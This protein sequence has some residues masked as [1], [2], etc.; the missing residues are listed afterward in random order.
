MHRVLPITLLAAV[1]LGLPGMALAGGAGP[2]DLSVRV[3]PV[4][5]DDARCALVRG[6]DPSAAVACRTIARVS[7]LE[8]AAPNGP[9][10]L[11]LLEPGRHDVPVPVQFRGM[12]AVAGPGAVQAVVNLI[13]AGSLIFSGGVQ[14]AYVGV[15]GTAPGTWISSAGQFNWFF[16]VTIARARAN[17]P[18]VSMR[19]NNMHLFNSLVSAPGNEN[20]VVMRGSGSVVGSTISGG[21]L[22][23]SADG[24]GQD[25][26]A[27]VVNASVLQGGFTSLGGRPAV[28]NS[29]ITTPPQSNSSA[30]KV[31]D[32]SGL[33]ADAPVN[34]PYIALSSIWQRACSP[35]VT[36]FRQGP[37]GREVS[38][39][40]AGSLVRMPDP[41]CGNPLS[42][43][44]VV[45]AVLWLGLRKR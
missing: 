38:L 35:A 10:V 23:V 24:G 25:A 14:A 12:V 43:A 15:T 33:A 44:L 16:G 18:T 11:M 34:Y 8:N 27:P 13:G 20:A 32:E 31:G 6:N 19:G 2:N 9:L 4:A 21:R 40:L 41:G 30:V 22:A 7:A 1:T 45:G 42:A 39:L 26:S 36:M 17:A 5:G 3:D 28:Y 37:A 29:A